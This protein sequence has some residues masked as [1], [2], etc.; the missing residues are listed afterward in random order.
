MLPQASNWIFPMAVHLGSRPSSDQ[1]H[2]FPSHFTFWIIVICRSGKSNLTRPGHRSPNKCWLYGLFVKVRSGCL[3]Q[4]PHR[5]HS[6]SCTGFQI[7]L[8]IWENLRVAS[9]ALQKPLSIDRRRSNHSAYPPSQIRS[10]MV[11]S[12]FWLC[13]WGHLT[14]QKI[15]LPSTS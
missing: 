11:L 13:P 12:T 2:S 7:M 9:A 14:L 6:L 15:L 8:N 5:L 3:P 10:G 1:A 4:G